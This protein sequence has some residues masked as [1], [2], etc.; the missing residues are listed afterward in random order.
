MVSY[1]F[2]IHTHTIAS[3]HGSPR[4]HHRHGKSCPCKWIGNAWNFRPRSLYAG[5]GKAF[6]F[7]Q[8]GERPQRTPG[9]TYALRR[10]SQYPGQ[11]RHA[12]SGQR[13]ALQS[14]LRDRQYPSAQK[15]GYC[16]GE[17]QSLYRCYGT[18]FLSQS[19]DTVMTRNIRRLSGSCKSRHGTSCPSGDQQ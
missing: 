11:Q 4:Y 17:Y 19:S 8:P 18:P 7:P 13:T 14:R 5:R 9:H 12:R 6:L 15:T 1:V 3:G 10:G 2:D 16:R